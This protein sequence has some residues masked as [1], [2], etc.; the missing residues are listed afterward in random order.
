MEFACKCVSLEYEFSG[1]EFH[2]L[3]ILKS[4]MEKKIEIIFLCFRDD[5]TVCAAELTA[6]CPARSHDEAGCQAASLFCCMHGQ[7]LSHATQY[8]WPW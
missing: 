3:K 7:C 6:C 1:Y 2:D 8:S 4:K 5:F